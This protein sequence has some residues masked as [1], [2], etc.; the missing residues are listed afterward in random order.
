[1][2]TSLDKALTAIVMGLIYI[3]TYITGHTFGF[4]QGAI[5]LIITALTPILV[6]LIPNK[7]PSA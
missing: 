7:K 5:G 3:Y 4:D 6:Y 1:M 2:F